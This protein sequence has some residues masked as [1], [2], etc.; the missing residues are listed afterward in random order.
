[1]AK[2]VSTLGRLGAPSPR[3]PARG[4][5]ECH[6]PALAIVEGLLNQKGTEIREGTA[7]LLGTIQQVLMHL[8]AEGDGDAPRVTLQQAKA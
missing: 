5:L 2:T 3:P 1:M 8:M 7:F 6:R 4:R